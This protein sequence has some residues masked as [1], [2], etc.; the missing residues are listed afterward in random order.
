[1]KSFHFPLQ[2]ALDLRSK[3][4]ELEEVRYKQRLFDLAELDR[5]RMEVGASSMRAEVQVREWGTVASCDLMAL[6]NFRVRARKLEAQILVR[7]VEAAAQVE[8]QQQT[9]LEARRRCR[10]LERLKERRMAE[11]TV[12]R[13]H[14]LDEI[15]AESYLARWSREA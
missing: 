12:A 1:M 13:D 11:W 7:R 9:M 3:Q 14:E 5:K 2:K 10:L 15:A 8:T 6:G 4:L